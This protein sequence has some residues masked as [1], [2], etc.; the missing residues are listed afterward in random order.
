MAQR[1]G[2][3]SDQTFARRHG[4]RVEP[5]DQGWRVLSPRR[6]PPRFGMPYFASES[7]AWTNAAKCAR[8][9]EIRGERLKTE[10]HE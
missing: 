4:Y 8:A 10:K 3:E 2:G 7:L 6:H 5:N 9:R 1:V